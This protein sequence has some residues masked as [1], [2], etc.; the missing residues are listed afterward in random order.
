MTGMAGVLATCDDLWAMGGWIARPR[1]DRESLYFSSMD[2]GGT[3][4]DL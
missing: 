1:V 4:K 3:L 2:D